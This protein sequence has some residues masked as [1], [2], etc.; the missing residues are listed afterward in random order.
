MKKILLLFL[1]GVSFSS[2][3]QEK[4]ETQIRFKEY[5][6]INIS[7]KKYQKSLKAEAYKIDKN[8]GENKDYYVDENGVAYFVVSKEEDVLE[9]L[10]RNWTDNDI[11]SKVSTDTFVI[12]GSS[13]FREKKKLRVDISNKKIIE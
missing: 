1:L 4:N 8:E 5:Y 7:Q 10:D 11:I 9:Y 2:F 6:L 13:N 3:S 12:I